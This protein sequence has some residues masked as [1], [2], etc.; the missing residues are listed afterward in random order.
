MIFVAAQSFSQILPKKLAT[1]SLSTPLS[2]V[3]PV[4]MLVKTIPSNQISSAP[5]LLA[6]FYANHLG[7]FCKQEIKFQKFVKVPF[8]FRLGGVEDCDKLEGKRN[9]RN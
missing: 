5:F 3:G 4:K 1:I 7:F 9:W 8:K 2:N 6:N